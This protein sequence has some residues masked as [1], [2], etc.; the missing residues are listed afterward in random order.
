MNEDK[1]EG[2]A[3]EAMGSVR[4]K[5]GDVTDNEE[6]QA[7]GAEQKHEGK[8]QGMMGS[9]KEKAEELKDKVTGH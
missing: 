4:E 8:A 2:K 9:I 7:K 1:V 3:K 6:M 5:A